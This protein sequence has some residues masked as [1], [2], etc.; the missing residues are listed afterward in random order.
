MR[1]REHVCVC[2]CERE[3]VCVCVCV[4]ERERESMCERERERESKQLQIPNSS[5]SHSATTF[6]TTGLDHAEH[7]N[8]GKPRVTTER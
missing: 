4:R 6:Q 7:L 5:Y 1:E 8:L 2:V 3:N